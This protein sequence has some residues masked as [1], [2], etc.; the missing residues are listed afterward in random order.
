M[1]YHIRIHMEG[2]MLAI[3]VYTRKT[4][5][6]DTL[7]FHPNT[8]QKYLYIATYPSWDLIRNLD[9]ILEQIS[10]MYEGQGIT[11]S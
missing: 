4:Q 10:K 8:L 5:S 2:E 3:K 9:K 7:N 6:I 1:N 11:M